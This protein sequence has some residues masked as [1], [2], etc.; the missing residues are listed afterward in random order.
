MNSLA[1]THHRALN[2]FATFVACAGFLLI[3][4]GAAVTSHDAGMS[5][6]DW[7]TTFGRSPISYSYYQVPLVGGV[8]WEH[9]HRMLAEFVGVLTILLVAWVMARER[10]PWVRRLGL[11]GLGLVVVQGIFGGIT[12]LLGLPPWSSTVHAALGQSFFCVAV[13]LA[14]FTGSGWAVC[15]NI[16]ASGLKS[17]HAWGAVAII[18]V[19]LILGSLFRHH[20]L[21]LMPHI[22]GACLVTATLLWT[23]YRVFTRHRDNVR[24]YFAASLLLC[25]LLLQLGLGIMSYLTRLVWAA[26]AGSVDLVMVASTVAHVAVGALLLATAVAL[27]LELGHRPADLSLVGETAAA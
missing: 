18:F 13:A 17:G 15:P 25:L 4:V 20:G 8:R 21:G 9:G 14:L 19:Q 12:V 16:S 23:T 2:T 1:A 26:P 7:P 11:I 27:A 10:R 5:V 24:L 3:V 22:L 6:P